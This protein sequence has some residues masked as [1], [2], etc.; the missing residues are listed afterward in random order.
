[1]AGC[2]TLGLRAGGFIAALS[3]AFL[4]LAD[5][6]RGKPR[7]R[8]PRHQPV[9]S[10]MS[11]KAKML[12]ARAYGDARPPAHVLPRQGAGGGPGRAGPPR[13]DR[14]VDLRPSR[15]QHLAAVAALD[16]LQRGLERSV[17]ALAQRLGGRARQGWINAMDGN[18]YRLSFFTF[19][20][21][22]NSGSKGNAY[23]GAYTI[24]APLNRRLELIV[25]I[26][27]AL[28]N[29]AV[30]GL[31]IIDPNNP[32]ARTTAQSHSG[33]GDVSFTPR[34]LLHETKDFSL[35]AELAVVTPTGNQP[36]AGKTTTLVP[37]VGFWN[38]FA[39]GWVIRGGLGLAIPTDGSRG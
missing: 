38:N 6:A 12:A 9:V 34:V 7:H 20:Q 3:V 29:N 17:G 18:L 33:F 39:G 8:R 13:D 37:A 2:Q 30:T 25:N 22:F 24:L 5:L 10:P 1:M 32:R 26:P 16:V 31:P 27:F 35:T 4:T 15:C 11:P 19:A 36:L 21:G 23:L 14:R 28:R